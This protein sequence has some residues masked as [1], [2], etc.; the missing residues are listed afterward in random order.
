MVQCELYCSFKWKVLKILHVKLRHDVL[1][2][3]QENLFVSAFSE[4]RHDVQ[5]DKDLIAKG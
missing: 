1:P 4:L 2:C 5:S 3:I